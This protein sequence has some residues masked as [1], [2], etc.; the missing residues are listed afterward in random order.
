MYA[1]LGTRPDLMHPVMTLS[2][3]SSCPTESHLIAAKRVLRYVAHTITWKLFYPRKSPSS[4]IGYSDSSYA[5]CPDDRRSIT[6][7]IFQLNGCTITWASQKQRSVAVSSTEAEYMALSLTARQAIWLSSGLTEIGFPLIPN[8]LC[9]NQGSISLSKDPRMHKRS[10]HID[11]HYHFTREKIDDGKISV[12]Y[13]P[14]NLNIA[15][16]FTKALGKSQF[17]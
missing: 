15:D 17:M 7:N 10:K 2:Q 1:A 5:S 12:S 3:Y 4:L 11:V 6:G 8:I 14:T 16:M 9:D 13:I